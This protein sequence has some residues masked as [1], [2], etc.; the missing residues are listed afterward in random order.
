MLVPEI[1]EKLKSENTKTVV[2]FGIEAHVCVQQTALDLIEKGIDVHVVADGVS[3]QRQFDRFCAFDRMRQSGVFVTTT[4]SAI[5]S[6][7]NDSR[8]E[9]FKAISGFLKE[10]NSNR[11]DPLLTNK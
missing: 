8:H 9:H 2:L 5:F 4:E 6:L 1:T 3:S 7:L 11:P 10:Y